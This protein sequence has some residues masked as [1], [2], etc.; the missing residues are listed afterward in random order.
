MSTYT[1]EKLPGEPIL[2][3]TA[4]RDYDVSV[5]IVKAAAEVNQLLDELGEPVFFVQDLMAVVIDVDDMLVGSN[6]AGGSETA[7]FRHPNIREVVAATQ[8][9]MLRMALEGMANETYGNV[10]VSLFDNIDDAMA[11][12]RSA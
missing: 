1:I 10:R 4:H 12:V 6:T 11:Y 9:Q 7:T 2:L 3:F 8:D 5:D